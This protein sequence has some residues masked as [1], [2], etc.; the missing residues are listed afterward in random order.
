MD[1]SKLRTFIQQRSIIKRRQPTEWQK[2]FANYISGKGPYPEYEKKKKYLQL[3]N[4]AVNSTILRKMEKLELAISLK[5][6][7]KW[8]IRL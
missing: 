6:I 2:I 8:S 5:K 1:L 3:N 7:Y 4:R